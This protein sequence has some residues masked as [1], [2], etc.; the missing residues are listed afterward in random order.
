MEGEKERC[1]RIKSSKKSQENLRTALVDEFIHAG[2]F[3]KMNLD[4]GWVKF[5]RHLHSI[6]SSIAH[7][8][9]CCL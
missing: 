4:R 1:K 9:K 2:T 8:L 7:L 3:P 5:V 6:D